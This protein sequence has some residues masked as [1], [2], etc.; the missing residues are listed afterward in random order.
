MKTLGRYVV[1]VLISFDQLGNSILGGDPDETISSRIGRIKAK[2]GGEI[3]RWR[4]MT[5][6][7]AWWLDK[8]DPGHC[9][10]AVEHD[11]G[12]GGI[13]DNR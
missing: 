7:T 11:E 3:P 10:D 13:W 4:V 6:F 12:D 9:E 8:I 5:R 1:N 2:W